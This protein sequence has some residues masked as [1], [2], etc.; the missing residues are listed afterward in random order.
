ML[1]FISRQCKAATEDQCLLPSTISVERLSPRCLVVDKELI[2]RSMVSSI[3]SGLG[4]SVIDTDDG[5]HALA[6][7]KTEHPFD[8]LVTETQPNGIDGRTLTEAFILSYRLG[9]VVMMSAD[10]DVSNVNMESSGSWIVVSKRYLSEALF[11]AIRWLGL[12]H[13]QRVILLAED[14]PGLRGFLRTILMQAGHAVISAVDGQEALE[15]SRTYSGRIDLVVSDVNM[16]RMT[17]S[18]LAE[19]ILHER[20]ATPVLLMSGNASN[21]L[22]EYATKHDFLSKPFA[23]KTFI[24]EVSRLLNRPK[25]RCGVVTEMH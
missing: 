4:F 3:L 24:E 14:E 19:H 20:P 18:D 23:P 17:G 12:A 16:P 8:L 15:L 6:L 7:L 21:T 1:I 2:I 10:D 13:S 25:H 9:R 11:G 5:R 22:V